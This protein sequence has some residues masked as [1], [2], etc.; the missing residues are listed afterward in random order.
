MA[1]ETPKSKNC[2]FIISSIILY[3]L[4]DLPIL[5]ICHDFLKFQKV[6]KIFEFCETYK[7]NL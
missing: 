6:H 4:M 5:F 3:S 7:S 2:K 1:V